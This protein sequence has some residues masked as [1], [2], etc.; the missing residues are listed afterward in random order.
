MRRSRDTDVQKWCKTDGVRAALN[1]FLM[2]HL[3]TLTT[4]NNPCEFY[5]KWFS[6]DFIKIIKVHPV[7]MIIFK[8]AL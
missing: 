3:V 1:V 8:N 7:G 6:Q 2:N 5:S 4:S